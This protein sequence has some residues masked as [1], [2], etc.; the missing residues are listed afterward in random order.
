MNDYKEDYFK[1]ALVTG[2]SSGIG[3][4]YALVLAEKMDRHLVIVARRTDRLL[5]LKSRIESMW[6]AMG[7]GLSQ[8][9]V[10]VW[11]CDLRQHEQRL[12]LLE[13][14][15]Q[16]GLDIDL[17]INNA[18]FGSIGDFSNS[19]LSWELDMISLN[20]QAAL[21]LCHYY[22][23]KMKEK[24][25]GTIINVCSTAAFQAMP[26]MAT[27]A[28]TKSFL[29]SFSLAL[30]QELKD[31]GVLVCAQCPGPTESE[32]HQV[33]GLKEKIDT[34]R[35]ADRFEVVRETLGAVGQRKIIIVNGWLNF[36]LS[37]LNRILP[38][39][40][41]AFVVLKSLSNYRHSR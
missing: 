7:S 6:A 34:L 18:G 41:S 12:K 20:C 36:F 16:T 13:E 21:H 11:T 30:S 15:E 25:Q 3:E 29:L 9:K 5:D 19:E 37:Q 33:V 26:Y 4:A 10:F 2:A 38:R 27:Y 24:E 8:P 39:Q 1:C 17:L 23:K 35:S 14:I 40:F 22:A 32:F 28:A 31:S